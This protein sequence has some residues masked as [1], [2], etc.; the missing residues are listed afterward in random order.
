MRYTLGGEPTQ[1]VTMRHV[2]VLVLAGLTAGCDPQTAPGEA[3]ASARVAVG[4]F[5]PGG[6]ALSIE[7]AALPGETLD[8]RVS[9]A[10]PFDTVWLGRGTGRQT[11]AVCPPVLGG[12]CLDV[13]QPVVQGTV[14]A[15]GSGNATVQVQVPTNIPPGAEGWFQAVTS[16]A[17][18]N[19]VPKF[20][21][22]E[23]G[24]VFAELFI[25]GVYRPGGGSEG[26]YG[27][28]LFGGRTGLDWCRWGIAF[29]EDPGA[30]HTPASC[31]RC[32]FLFGTGTPDIQETDL[33]LAGDCS[34]LIGAPAPVGTNGNLSIGWKG[35]SGLVFNTRYPGDTSAYFAAWLSDASVN[36]FDPVT[37]RFRARSDYSSAYGYGTPYASY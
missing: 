5:T 10:L 35:N 20:N 1:G 31:P 27:L 36:T 13:A 16:T 11:G 15:D 17:S 4:G 29:V 24:Q 7:G 33:T 21:P 6:L 19:V 25:E 30:P 12:G 26:A 28:E 37:G 34:L 3:G 22:F 8:V 2:S 32:D 23:R 18:S 9:G 14:T